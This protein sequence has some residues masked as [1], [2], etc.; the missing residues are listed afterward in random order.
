MPL[1]NDRSENLLALL[2][3]QQLKTSS[4]GEKAQQL[5]VAGFSNSE[6]ADLLQTNAAVISQ[7]LYMRR[8]PGKAK[9]KK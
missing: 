4:T 9:K 8:K 5:S 7:L 6:I 1:T 3:L 2:L